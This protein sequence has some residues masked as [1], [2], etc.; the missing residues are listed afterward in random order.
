[1]LRPL[2]ASLIAALFLAGCGHSDDKFVGDAPAAKP[3][4]AAAAQPSVALRAP[5]DARKPFV[6]IR[7]ETPDPDYGAALYTA[8]SGALRRRPEARFDL[9]AVTRDADAAKRN[10]ADVVH[11]IT[12]MGMPGERLTL[13]AAAAADAATDEVWIY[14]R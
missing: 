9:V 7:F 14:L 11:T 6:V 10:L 4:V 2:A 13:S 1:M 3:P 5:T 8:L 12:A